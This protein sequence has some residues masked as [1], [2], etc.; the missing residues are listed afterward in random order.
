M[1]DWS[2]KNGDMSVKSQGVLICCV[3]GNP[4]NTYSRR[5]VTYKVII[6]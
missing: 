5:L 6:L 3:S 1:L 4:V 2:G